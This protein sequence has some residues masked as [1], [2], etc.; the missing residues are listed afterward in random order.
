MRQRQAFTLVELLVVLGVLGTLMGLLLPA[1][2]AA[3]E[4]A[5]AVQCQSNLHQI[6]IDVLDGEIRQRVIPNYTEYELV[7]PSIEDKQLAKYIQEFSGDRREVLINIFPYG[8]TSCTIAI[9]WE[10]EYSHSGIRYGVYLDGHVAEAS[11]LNTG[12]Y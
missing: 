10:P 8:Y 1:V 9:V 4:A 2:Q 7:C 11:S 6:G 5:R 3:R 12:G